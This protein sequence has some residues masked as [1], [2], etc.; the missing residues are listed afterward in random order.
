MPIIAN[1]SS[2]QRPSP[3]S[4]AKDKEEEAN[5][6]DQ[7]MGGG[8]PFGLISFKRALNGDIHIEFM[9]LPMRVFVQLL[10][11]YLRAPVTDLTGLEG[12]YH[13]TLDF[14]YRIFPDLSVSHEDSVGDLFM[15]VKRLGLGLRAKRISCKVL[16]VDHV[17]QVPT[18][19]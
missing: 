2:G 18:A 6:M 3:E 9:K 13:V 4:I 19:N 10:A 15:A 17:E 14:N 1:L 5:S 11:D 8:K 16:I 7:L 12:R